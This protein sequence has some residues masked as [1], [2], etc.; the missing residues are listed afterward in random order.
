MVQMTL[1][2]TRHNLKVRMNYEIKT[3]KGFTW[4]ALPT[5]WK[6]IMSGLVWAYEDE[7]NKYK[8]DDAIAKFGKSLPTKEEWEL[9]E[10]HGVREV[11]SLHGNMYWS[12]SVYSSNRSGAWYF[13]SDYGFVSNGFR[14]TTNSVRLIVR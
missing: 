11:L 10:K 2:Q 7:P 13:N 4:I 14:D 5:G 1:E 6:D 9:A 12:A 8:Y 3:S